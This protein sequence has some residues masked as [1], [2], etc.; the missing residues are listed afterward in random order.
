[1]TGETTYRLF[2][3]RDAFVPKV[4]RQH[5]E[6]STALPPWKRE[7]ALKPPGEDGDDDD[8][9][10]DDEEEKVEI[11]GARGRDGGKG[12]EKGEERK[13]EKKEERKKDGKKKEGKKKGGKKTTERSRRC[14][15]RYVSV[16]GVWKEVWQADGRRKWVHS[17]NKRETWV[18]PY[19]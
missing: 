12:E 6:D 8:E 16:Q 19:C 10:E 13:E 3:E 4:V 14:Q 18:D 2:I 11:M 7:V 17:G 15:E 9:E 5:V 1:M